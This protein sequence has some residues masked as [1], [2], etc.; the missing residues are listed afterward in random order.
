[1]AKAKARSN[2]KKKKKATPRSTRRLF[3]LIGATF[4]AAVAGLV[5]VGLIAAST[6]SPPK[7]KAAATPGGKPA[8]MAAAKQ[9]FPPRVAPESESEDEEEPGT[10]AS[11]APPIAPAPAVETPKVIAPPP[12][13]APGGTP[14]WQ[15]NAVA[16]PPQ[17]GPQVAI[18]IDDAGLDHPRTAKAIALPAPLTISFLTYGEGLEQQVRAA[19]AA[20]HELMVHVAM[21]PRSKKEN[22]GPD[23]L[24]RDAPPEEVMGRLN[25]M[26][27]RFNGYVGI[28]NHMGSLF[29]ADER[30]M[31]LVVGE[32]K[33]R[34]LLFLDSRTGSDSVGAKVAR[35][36]GVPY[37]ERD[38]FLDNTPTVPEVMKQL[39]ELER[40]ARAKGAAVAIGHP[41]DGTIAAMQQWIPQAKAR[42]LVFVPVSAIVRE[43]VAKGA[44]TRR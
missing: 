3:A 15:K 37:A 43:N 39:A 6:H 23:V 19:S 1:M 2:S 33:R 36:Q 13:L 5:M 22:P 17:S 42:G 34:G 24:L 14:P 18:V 35:E 16:T 40:I 31:E 29:T 4:G 21:Q 30:S 7:A 20:G 32:L 25:K 44:L 9:S 8:V 26:L 27:G 38:V 41:H 11:L 28:N 10:T 12:A